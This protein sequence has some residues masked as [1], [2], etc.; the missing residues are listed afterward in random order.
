MDVCKLAKIPEYEH[1]ISNFLQKIDNEMSKNSITER[2]KQLHSEKG[3]RLL[4]Q[5]IIEPILKL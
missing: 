1:H 2:I 4:I 5:Y 3:N